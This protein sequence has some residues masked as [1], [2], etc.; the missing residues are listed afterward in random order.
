MLL[1]AEQVEAEIR[2]EESLRFWFSKPESERIRA[3]SLLEG[4]TESSSEEDRALL[5]AV[6]KILAA[7][8]KF[9]RM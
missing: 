3:L 2:L 7:V 8:N 6:C 5:H 1:T 9:D 4:F